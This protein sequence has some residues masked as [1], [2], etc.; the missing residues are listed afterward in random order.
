MQSVGTVAIGGA[1]A[2]VAAL[3]GAMIATA[4]DG[5]KMAMDLEAQMDVIASVLNKTEQEAQPLNDLILQLGIN[6][7]LKVS[8]LEAAD[9]IQTLATAGLSMGQIIEGAAEATILLSNASGGDFTQS[10]EIMTDSMAIFTDSISS[11]QDA[12]NGVI[13]VS[14]VSKF[15]VDDYALALAQAGGIAGTVGVEFDD[16]NTSI[17]AISSLFASGSDAGTSYKTMLQRLVPSTN[18]AVDAMRDLGLFTGLTDKEFEKTQ[19]TIAKYKN[20]LAAL[21]PKSKNFAKKSEEL[22]QKIGA[23]NSTLVTG[24]NAFYDANGNLKDMAD[25]SAILNKAL[26]GLSEEEKSTA[27]TTIFGTDA[28]RAAVGMAD[29]GVVAYTDAALA[30]KELGVSQEAVNAVMEGG[31]TQFEALQLQMGKTDA[32]EQAKQRVDNAKGVLEVFG[33]VAEAVKI[34]IGQ[35]FL[36]TIKELGLQFTNFLSDNSGSII[37]FFRSFAEGLAYAATFIPSML[38]GLVGM[39]RAAGVLVGDLGNFG[40]Q[41]ASAIAPMWNFVAPMI[42]AVASFVSWKDA[43]VALGVAVGSVVLPAL[44]GIA[45]TLSPIVLSVG[46]V[47]AASALLRTAWENDFL[48]MRTAITNFSTALSDL[49]GGTDFSTLK[50]NVVAAFSDIGTTVRDFFSGGVSLGGIASVVSQGL[51]SIRN[52]LASVFG[53]E[54]FQSVVGAIAIAWNGLVA[55][56][57]SSFAAIDW[58]GIGNSL[59]ALPFNVAA[60]FMSIDWA[61]IGGYLTGL[62]TS[63]TSW[64]SGIDWAGALTSFSTSVTNA[65][66]ALDWSPVTTAFD[67]LK[68]N[69]TTALEPLSTA[70]SEKFTALSTAFSEFK[71]PTLEEI[72]ASMNGFRDNALSGLTNAIT[73]IDWTGAGFDFAGMVNGLTSKINS[74]DWSQI[75]VDQ[76][77]VA[78]AAVVAPALTAGVAAITWVLSSENFS[79]LTTAVK[80]A[81]TSIPWAD[82]G[83]SFVGLGTAV[84][85]AIAGLDWT[86]VTTAFDTLKTTVS[87]AI[88]PISTAISDAFTNI[89][90]AIGEFKMPTLEEIGTSLNG[91]RDAAVQSLADSFTD[92]DLTE[93]ISGLLTSVTTAISGIDWT[94]IGSAA[95]S[96]LSTAL[97]ADNL[98]LA[99]AGIA[100][101]VAPALTASIAGI[102]WVMSSENW[103]GLTTAVMDSIKNIDWAAVGEKFTAL[104][105]AIVT[106]LGDF[107]T[108]FTGA[109]ATPA[110][111]TDLMAWDMPSPTE[112]LNW[113]FPSPAALIG[114]GWPTFPTWSWPSLPTWSWPSLPSW[115]WPSIPAPSWLSGLFGGGNAVGTNYWGGGVSLV[116]ETGPELVYMPRGSKVANSGQTRAMLNGGGGDTHVYVTANVDNG[117]DINTLAY[118]IADVLRRRNR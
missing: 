30:A 74:I 95:G 106:A 6:P 91:F 32:L 86:T 20:Q 35:G 49:V 90:T 87:G 100:T 69:V 111:L 13:A 104:K 33:G 83:E 46:A 60:Y 23:L 64:F 112:L 97:S 54:T 65:L 47:I 43:M 76:I 27:L 96:A 39:G 25:I 40:A 45:A 38:S 82:I 117:I 68:T 70:V 8:T 5:T 72:G 50:S 61:G 36:P 42:A 63:V 66:S 2:G 113:T 28:M 1:V 101:W 92:L 55:I 56:V 53:S 77:G 93:K 19:A 12:V 18:P 3:G 81:F 115:T 99:F 11:Y 71:L 78:L 4:V 57:Q 80:G 84:G 102:S 85:T 16:F 9:A 14:N 118:E 109:F 88:A 103:S 75:S 21:D 110:W 59:I 26:A 105:D 22:N 116:G 94:G 107:A 24:S 114:W 108:G 79:G 37:A 44:A 51:D 34:S 31:I 15:T 98:K 73:G 48:G 67:T 29:A 41:I 52:T 58:T 17:A 10:A 62:Y 7:N 89:S